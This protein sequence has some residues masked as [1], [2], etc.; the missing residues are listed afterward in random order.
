MKK[1]IIYF[2]AVLCLSVFILPVKA[3]A[4]GGQINCWLLWGDQP[5][6][7]GSIEICRAGEPVPEG[8]RLGPEFGGGIVAG[9]DTPSS[10]FALWM[11]EKARPGEVKIIDSNGLACFTDLKPGLYLIRQFQESSKFLPVDP[12]IA[13]IPDDLIQVDTYPAV[14]PRSQTPKTGQCP[15]IFFGAMGIAVAVTGLIFFIKE[16]KMRNNL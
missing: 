15:E 1:W 3:F 10:A 11:S 16:E 7:D 8:Y 12:Y 6:K 9:E 14:Y 4:E 13:C 5:V 2:Y